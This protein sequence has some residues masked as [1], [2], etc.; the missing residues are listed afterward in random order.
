M[1]NIIQELSEFLTPLPCFA[2]EP[3]RRAV[4][5]NAG[6]SDLLPSVN[7]SGSAY[8]CVASLLDH[9]AK[10][11][12]IEEQIALL[13][14][15]YKSVGGE[16]K[17]EITRL[18]ALLNTPGA[19]ATLRASAPLYAPAPTH[20]TNIY[21]GNV[22]VQQGDKP[23]A[24]NTQFNNQFQNL[25]GDLIQG[26]QNFTTGAKT[27]N[28]HTPQDLTALL[29][30]LQK[31]IAQAPLPE[32]AKEEMAHEVKTAEIQSKKEK[33]DKKK[34]ADALDNAKAILTKIGETVP[35]AVALGQ[36]LGKA[37]DYVGQWL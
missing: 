15:V 12:Q 7:L 33:P 5:I 22:T 37:I 18:I 14:E 17:K 8:D 3:S 19:Q 34:A 26:S 25:N 36:M 4:L 6:L 23:M 21:G 10:S 13:Q 35:Q 29:V 31:M 1:E 27:Y 9:F 28:L 2:N 11:G 30:E 16:K 32:D 20:Q 24:T